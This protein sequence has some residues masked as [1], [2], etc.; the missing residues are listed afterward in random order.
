M[1]TSEC[2]L[3]RSWKDLPEPDV[4]RTEGWWRGGQQE[5]RWRFDAEA[6]K[7]ALKEKR[8]T[9]LQKFEDH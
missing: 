3:D 4:G 1:V 8:E 7:D 9:C 6:G 2:I 5:A